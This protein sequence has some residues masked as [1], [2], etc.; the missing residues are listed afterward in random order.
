MISLNGREVC[1]SNFPNGESFADVYIECLYR[2]ENRIVFRFEDD[3]DIVH[4]QFVKDFVDANCS[5]NVPCTLIMPYI[6]Y[7]RMDRHEQ[8]RLFTLKSFANIINRMGF[9]EVIV[10][11]PHS[12]VSVA[13]LNNVRVKNVSMELTKKAMCK[14]LG[15]TGSCWV[16]PGGVN[17]KELSLEGMLKKADAEHIY[18]VY[19]DAGAEKRYVKQLN[20][21]NYLV[22]EK[23]RDFDTGRIT[24][25]NLVGAERAENCKTA[26]I[27]DD[28][29]SKGGTFVAAANEIKKKLPNV[30]NIFLCVTHCENNIFN[31]SIFVDSPINTVYTTDS[32]LNWVVREN[33][34]KADSLNKDK[35]TVCDYAE[36][37]RR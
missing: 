6:P 13:L 15:L 34:Y 23:H 37:C 21:S 27:V 3:S 29:C 10:L 31:G 14:I 16:T 2:S 5:H 33:F 17:D 12:D 18:L 30:E 24:S 25:F 4:L 11:E 1:F 19:P 32:I 35:L 8:N 9:D 26:I 22:C 28:L 36:F 20:Y 7:S